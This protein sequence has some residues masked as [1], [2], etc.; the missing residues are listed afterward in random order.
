ME[1]T[2][3]KPKNEYRCQGCNNT[4]ISYGDLKI[5]EGV[6]PVCCK[7]CEFKV[8]YKLIKKCEFSDENI[9]FMA[10][11]SSFYNEKEDFTRHKAIFAICKYYSNIGLSNIKYL[12]TKDNDKKIGTISSPHF[13]DKSLGTYPP[14]RG[15][16]FVPKDPNHNSQFVPNSTGGNLEKWF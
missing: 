5:E 12:G 9:E 3:I 10:K 13:R 1:I 7:Q 16:S 6:L 14:I 11:N 2:K 8:I 15:M 4:F